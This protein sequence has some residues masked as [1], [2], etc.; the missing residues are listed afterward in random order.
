[1]G[2]IEIVLTLA[3]C[4][5]VCWLIMQIPML[6]VFK[7]LIVGV[8]VICLVIWVLQNFGLVHYNLHLR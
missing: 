7:N 8:I 2:I 1:M 4:G 3:I 5:F 6:P